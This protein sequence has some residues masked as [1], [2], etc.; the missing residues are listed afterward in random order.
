MLGPAVGGYTFANQACAQSRD[1]DTQ[2]EAPGT[3]PSS[4]SSATTLYGLKK[5]SIYSDFMCIGVL[6]AFM[7]M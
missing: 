5:T 1:W 6:P 2:W 3:S 7:S 4:P